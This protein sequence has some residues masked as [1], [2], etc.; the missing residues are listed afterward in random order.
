MM[1]RRVPWATN[2]PVLANALRTASERL[3]RMPNSPHVVA[4][5]SVVRGIEDDAAGWSTR[6]PLP[7]EHEAVITKL[8]AIHFALAALRPKRR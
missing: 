3:A 7:E 4:L 1:D 6:P 5:E 2:F 8:L